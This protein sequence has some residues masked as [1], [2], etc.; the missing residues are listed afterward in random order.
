[1]A[2]DVEFGGFHVRDFFV[3]ADDLARSDQELKG[4]LNDRFRSAARLMYNMNL[5][6]QMA[7]S[8]GVGTDYLGFYSNTKAQDLSMPT[9]MGMMD[10]GAFQQNAAMSGVVGTAAQVEA[11]LTE[12]VLPHTRRFQA[13]VD[14]MQNAN[15]A[16]LDPVT[17]RERASRLL[18]EMPGGKRGVIGAGLAAL[19][20]AGAS[21]PYTPVDHGRYDT[22]RS[23]PQ[24]Q[25]GSP[26][27]TRR[28]LEAARRQQQ[29]ADY[30]LRPG[31]SVGRQ[32]SVPPP[33]TRHASY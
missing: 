30:Y 22:P 31:V 10:F 25:R 28:A 24:Y 15:D 12:Q 17:L 6:T 5:S 23:Q 1:M 20:L 9:R 14:M 27:T 4:V 7:G 19:A 3:T 26:Q 29:Q 13:A 11:A 32:Y 2:D 16:T 33:P 18:G 21:Q 8:I